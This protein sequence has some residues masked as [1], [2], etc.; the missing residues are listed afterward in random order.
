MS[1]EMGQALQSNRG[2][3]WFKAL[4]PN[5]FGLWSLK[6]KQCVVVTPPSDVMAFPRALSKQTQMYTQ[7]DRN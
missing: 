3:L 7:K 6:T 5:I 4:P 1:L 2:L